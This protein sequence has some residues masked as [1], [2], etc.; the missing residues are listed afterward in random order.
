MND[1]DNPQTLYFLK[2][3]PI[4]VICIK[5][6][7]GVDFHLNP[8]D[9]DILHDMLKCTSN[10]LQLQPCTSLGRDNPISRT[11]WY[12]LYTCE[13]YVYIYDNPVF[14]QPLYRS[15]SVTTSDQSGDRRDRDLRRSR[16]IR[17]QYPR[18]DGR[19]ASSDRLM[20]LR[21]ETAI[22]R[23][24]ELTRTRVFWAASNA[25]LVACD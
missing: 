13:L 23:A 11:Y 15:T 22:N 1:R 20:F 24:C 12:S 5:P 19:D 8:I 10:L 7:C 6:T 18:N 17:S 2:Y 9:W 16:S 25:S 3:N 4:F 14:V 21:E